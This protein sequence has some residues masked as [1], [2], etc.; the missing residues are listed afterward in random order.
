M[1]AHRGMQH[2][3]GSKKKVSGHLL[4]QQR[5]HNAGS[6]A[7]QHLCP[8]TPSCELCRSEITHMRDRLR[9]CSGL[10]KS[11]RPGWACVGALVTIPARNAPQAAAWAAMRC[12]TMQRLNLPLASKGLSLPSNS[13][14]SCRLPDQGTH[15]PD[16]CG[17]GAPLLLLARQLAHY[18]GCSGAGQRV[19][20]PTTMQRCSEVEQSA[21]EQR[22]HLST[23]SG[24]GCA[25]L[26]E[27]WPLGR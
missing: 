14:A 17:D 5:H 2:V 1:S 6:H 20:A 22:G 18:A 10:N 19:C 25:L 7:Q 8:G 4:E 16:I 9:E 21:C 27:G 11:Y 15:A 24:M 3:C 26:G 13:T 12:P 23:F